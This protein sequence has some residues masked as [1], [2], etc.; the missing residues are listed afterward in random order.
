MLVAKYV[1]QIFHTLQAVHFD[2]WLRIDKA[3][4][5]HGEVGG[6]E[7]VKFVSVPEMLSVA[8]Y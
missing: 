2:D 3:E 4:K 1:K 8:E 6:R 5:K 7:R